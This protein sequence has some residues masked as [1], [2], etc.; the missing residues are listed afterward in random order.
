MYR[1]EDEREKLFTD[2]GQRMLLKV[3]DFVDKTLAVAGAVRMQEAVSAAG[4][5]SSW[6]MLACVDRLAELGEIR[7]ISQGHVVGQHRVFVR[8]SR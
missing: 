4:S 1:Y 2:E 6:A 3:R 7:E 8:G 5:G